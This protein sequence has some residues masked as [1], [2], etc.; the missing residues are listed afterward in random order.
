MIADNSMTADG[1]ATAFMVLGLKKSKRVLANQPSLAVF[2]I[3]D[4]NG[5]INTFQTNNFPERK[6]LN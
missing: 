1:Y 2:F 4:D 6:K 5:K 3:Y